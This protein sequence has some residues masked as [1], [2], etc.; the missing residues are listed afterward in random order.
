MKDS[1][2]FAFNALFMDPQKV[3]Q[4]QDDAKVSGNKDLE[5]NNVIR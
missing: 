3:K 1:D 2:A 5:E 4:I